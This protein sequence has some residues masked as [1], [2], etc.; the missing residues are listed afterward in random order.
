MNLK[1]TLIKEKRE[2][3]RVLILS[4]PNY[5]PWINPVFVLVVRYR[6][7]SAEETVLLVIDARCKEQ[8]V[9]RPCSGA[10]AKA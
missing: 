1:F 3:K 8:G 7:N 9:N 2:E 4:S 6:C 10:I 5:L